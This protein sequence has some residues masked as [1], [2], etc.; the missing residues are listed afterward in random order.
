MSYLKRRRCLKKR[1]L[2]QNK[3]RVRINQRLR[4]KI[5]KIPYQR[6]VTHS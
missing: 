6:R 2:K 5:Q 1:E 3:A 4:L